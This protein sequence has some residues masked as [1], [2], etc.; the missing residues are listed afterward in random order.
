[1]QLI[2]SLIIL[3][4]KDRKENHMKT[5]KKLKVSES[6]EWVVWDEETNERLGTIFYPKHAELTSIGLNKMFDMNTTVHN[7]PVF[8]IAKGNYSHYLA[9]YDRKD[10]ETYLKYLSRKE[11][12][13]TNKKA[14]E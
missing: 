3:T 1:M 14:K 12:K 13:N 4:M 9:F 6:M 10:A 11:N 5:I 8:R 7:M 2:V